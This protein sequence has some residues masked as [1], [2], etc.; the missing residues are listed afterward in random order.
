MAAGLTSFIWDNIYQGQ[1][2]NRIFVGMVDN[3]SFSGVYKKNPFNF[4]HY[5]ISKIGCFV[6][7]ESLPTQPLKLNF[8]GNQYLEGYRS[9]FTATGKINRDEGIDINRTDYKAGHTLFG[10]DISPSMCNGG[11]QEPIK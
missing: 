6:N 2:P 11:H 10:F 9:L 3:D 5:N 1:L 4:Q 7:G 8:A